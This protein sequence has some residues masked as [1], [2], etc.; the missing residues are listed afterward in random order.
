MTQAGKGRVKKEGEG[1][2]G[3][4]KVWM[5]PWRDERLWNR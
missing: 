1:S 3:V 4:G 5:R 2:V